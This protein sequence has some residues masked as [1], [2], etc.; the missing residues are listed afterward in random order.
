MSKRRLS[1]LALCVVAMLLNLAPQPLQ[2]EAGEETLSHDNFGK[3]AIYYPADEPK[4][5]VLLLSGNGGWN[6][7]MVE[8]AR[9]VADLDYLVVGIDSTS[10]LARLNG[11]ASPCGDLATDFDKLRRFL[12]NYYHLPAD[13]APLLV[14]YGSGA[15][16]VY[17]TLAQAPTAAFHAVVS[18]DF[19]PRIALKKPLCQG[20][21]LESATA[22]DR[23]SI[24]LQPAKQLQTTW[25]VFQS[26]RACDSDNVTQF[27][28]ESTNAKLV[29]LGKETS[30]PTGQKTWL[31]QFTA[32]LQWLDPSITKQVQPD[33]DLSGVPL[34][35]IPAPESASKRLAV[36]ISGD[37]GWAALDRGVA[38]ELLKHGIGTV[39]WDSLSYF[40]QPKTPAQAGMDL[41]QVLQHYLTAWNKERALLIGYSFGADV[42]PFM[43]NQL[44]PELRER[45]ELVAFLGLSENASFEFHLSNWIGEDSAQGALPVP[46][47]VQKLTSV[48]RLCIYGEEEDHSACP[49]LANAGVLVIKM[50][51]DH[52]FD[53]DYQG[54]VKHLLE[55]IPP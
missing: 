26:E 27:V 52:H 51:G 53:D 31:P 16:L 12:E 3:L 32:L 7:D 42:L 40:W 21:S 23:K 14:G 18:V 22:P 8:V 44:T 13:R 47:E 30:K 46:P 34:T 28:R 9:V 10:Y 35:E 39:G 43:V 17:A 37:G 24:V 4:G 25:F 29:T 50:A 6:L 19:C 11:L 20:R 5:L 15:A 49:G 45:V 33:A 41:E 55:Q 48:K 54:I 2:E 36:M 1:L 38:A